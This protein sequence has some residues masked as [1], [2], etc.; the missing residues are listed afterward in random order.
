MIK[1]N[2]GN[3]LKGKRLWSSESFHFGLSSEKAGLSL[4]TIERVKKGHTERVYISKLNTLC[5]LSVGSKRSN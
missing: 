5:V 2:F 4:S 1:S 3:W